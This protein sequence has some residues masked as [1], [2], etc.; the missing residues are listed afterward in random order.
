[1]I[2]PYELK[3]RMKESKFER[4]MKNALEIVNKK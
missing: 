4:D 1:M 2:T 3:E